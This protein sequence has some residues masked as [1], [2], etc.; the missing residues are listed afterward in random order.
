MTR[1]EV[2]QETEQM[3]GLVPA[4]IRALP[5]SSDEQEWELFK[6]VQIGETV[7]PTGTANSLESEWLQ[8]CGAVIAHIIILK[9]KSFM[10][11]Q[12]PKLKMLYILP[13]QAQVGVHI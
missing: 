6:R 11:Q 10:E 5:D 9:L 4:F 8:F 12:M 2:Y 3:M 7:I 1:Q 13:N